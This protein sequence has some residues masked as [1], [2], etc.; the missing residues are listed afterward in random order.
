MCAANTS[1]PIELLTAAFHSND[2]RRVSELLSQFPAVKS[3]INDLI[4][5]FNSPPI[6]HVRDREMLDVLLAAGADINRKS[7]WWA[8]GFGLLHS[9]SPELAAY[10][11]QRGATVDIHAA[12]RLGMIDRVRECLAA[13]PGLVRA[14]GGDGQLPLHFASTTEIADVLLDNGADVDAR[15]IDHESTA[16]QYMIRDRQEIARHLIRRGAKSDILMAAAL[17]DR[18]LAE[19][20]LLAD[21]GCVR[22][23][24]SE[25][26]FPMIN[27]RSGGTIYQ[28]TL[29]WHVSAVQVARQFGHP[30]LASW[31]MERSPPDVRLVNACWLG[32]EDT[33]NALLRENPDLPEKLTESDRRQLGHAARNNDSRAVP[34]FLRARLP[35]NV[36]TQHGA[37]P[38]HWAAWHG[39]VEMVRSLL[40]FNPPLEATDADFNGTP[41][42]WAIHGSENGW[43]RDTGEYGPTT[44]ALLKAGAKPPEKIGGTPEVQEVLRRHR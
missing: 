2:A 32:E 26:Y 16:A 20:H 27:L 12:A 40:R 33:L 43:H 5:P 18:S 17:G 19:R 35:V 1:D 9:A 36:T 4:G 34:L 8:G 38:L 22:V 30:D 11:I 21:P 10:A 15:D 23:R 39:N 31:L 25:E 42:R 13:D 14:R 41:L 28:W 24:V 6:L 7:S 44:D 3:E 37:T 29:G